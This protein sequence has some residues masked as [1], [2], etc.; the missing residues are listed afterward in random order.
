MKLPLL[1]IQN[2][3]F[4]LILVALLTLLGIL[5]FQTMPRSEDPQFSFPMADITVAYPGTSPLDMEKLIADP[6]EKELNQLED[7]KEIKT[8]ITDGLA[9]IH[10]EF[11]YGVDSDKKYDDVVQSISKVRSQLPSEVQNIDIRQVSPTDVNVLQIALLSETAT[12]NKMRYQ[13]ERLEKIFTRVPGVKRAL[14]QAYPQQQIQITADLIVMRELGLT[15]SVLRNSLIGAAANSPGGFIDAGS[16]RF[17]VKTSGDFQSL[18]D[19]RRSV[20][21]LP[22]G[23]IIHLEDIANVALVDA[24]PTYLALHNGR[25]A[26]FISVQ[27]RESTNIFDVLDG[28]KA[29]L[30]S[31]KR[32][33]PKE[34]Q[35]EV[36]FDQSISVKKQVNGF[37]INLLQGLILVGLIILFS[38]GIR[39]ASII[40]FAIPVS[41]FIG[42]AGLDYFGFGLQQMSIVGLVI[43]L[44]LLVDNAIVVT[45]SIGQKLRLGKH[46]RDAAAMG[47]QQVSWAIA[48]GTATTVLAFVPML[49][50]QTDVGTFMRSMPVTVVLVLIASFFIAITLTPLMASRMF[51]QRKVGESG[52]GRNIVQKKLE[53]LSNLHYKPALNATLKRPWRVIIISLFLFIISLGLFPQVGV[54][55][56]PKAE[57]PLLLVN[58]ELPESSSFY[59]TKKLSEQIDKKI[60]SYSQVKAVAT[61]IGRDNPSIYY[62]EF[63]GGE[64]PNIAQLFIILNKLNYT[65]L[66]QLIKN[67]RRDFLLIAGAKLRVKEFQQGP[68]LEAP[69]AIRIFG[70]NLDE[71]K[72]TADRVEALISTTAGTVNIKNP[73]GKPKMD[74][75]ININ[76]DKTALLNVDIANVDNTIRTSLVG[77][78]VGRY[79]DENGDDY[80]IVLR[81]NNSKTPQIDNL[82]ELLVMSN[83]GAFVPLKQLIT[84]KLQSV[85]SHLRHYYL[86][87]STILTADTQSGYL[88]AEVTKNII[89]QLK[90]LPLPAGV[91]YS[92][93]GEQKSRNNSFAGLIK[94]LIISLLGIFAVLVLQFRSFAQPAIVF[95]SI[96]FA[97]T[98]AILALL[99]F[100]YSFSVMA[101]VALTSLMGIV[102]NNSIILVDTANQ[103][104]LK[105]EKI[106]EAIANAA[107]T[108]LTPIVLTTLTTIG[109]L[110]PLTM[111]NSTMWTPLGLVII[112]GM[113]VSTVVTLFIVP[114]LY[115]LITREDKVNK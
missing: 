48:S 101:F 20:L 54:S 109:G 91:R 114:A 43:A 64:S 97:F 62:N 59:A 56:F 83:S 8:K 23:S 84:T 104:V 66:Q 16:K 61:N 2:H 38:L 42:I 44:G 75:E 39:A 72:T 100:G 4:T 49:M 25:R 86:E 22:D 73:M 113:L 93:A 115:L 96:P 13:A 71:L 37:F 74:I 79:R 40:L 99:A 67:L 1:A 18:K 78:I 82:N 94:A 112:G 107:Q 110:L 45:E 70:N 68:P 26:V 90:K 65:E 24:E 89:E 106:S 76:R 11:N 32:S 105:G 19:I 21:N 50:M 34:M 15:L 98:G 103:L 55:L 111:K 102:V 88:T 85:P 29:E 31:F 27:Q 52:K 51:K 81:L 12:Y 80:N 58:I 3:Q 28:L 47:T 17:S 41:I 63:P 46:P 69:I 9:S 30:E 7:I 108:R 95:A 77:N 6:I 87:R 36:V 53:R 60:R 35:I 57:K 5:S 14:A 33:L 92:I 10:I